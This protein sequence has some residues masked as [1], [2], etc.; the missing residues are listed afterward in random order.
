MPRPGAPQGRG[1]SERRPVQLPRG[2]RFPRHVKPGCRARKDEQGLVSAALGGHKGFARNGP[3]VGRPASGGAAREDGDDV[4]WRLPSAPRCCLLARTAVAVRSRARVARGRVRRRRWSHAPRRT[5]V[6]EASPL[7]LKEINRSLQVSVVW[8]NWPN[9]LVLP[10]CSKPTQ[11]HSRRPRV[12]SF[13][14]CARPSRPPFVAR[15]D[16]AGC[17]FG[18]RA[19][20]PVRRR[21]TTLVVLGAQAHRAAQH[22]PP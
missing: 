1:P 17:N 16:A 4:G 13:A 12:P 8:C 10:Q 7:S 6:A 18:R 14:E 15:V 11:A 20:R 9:R 19:V 2:G 21:P 3:D 5:P 22:L